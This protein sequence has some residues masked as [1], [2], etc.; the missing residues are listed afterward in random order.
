MGEPL[1]STPEG[2]YPMGSYYYPPTMVPYPM[3]PG[4]YGLPHQPMTDQELY[5]THDIPDHETWVHGYHA[6]RASEA[7]SAESGSFGRL[8]RKEVAEIK[9]VL[10]DNPDEVTN[11]VHASD[12]GVSEPC[13]PEVDADNTPAVEAAVKNIRSQKVLKKTKRA[14]QDVQKLAQAP[15]PV[16]ICYKE[17]IPSLK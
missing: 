10:F 11:T 8:K 2:L 4:Y 17:I 14:K 12:S 9:E 3:Y 13:T 7:D 16:V 6:E 15:E 1:I 5:N